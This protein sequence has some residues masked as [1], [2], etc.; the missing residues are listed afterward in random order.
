MG[1]GP[2]ET[3]MPRMAV[4]GPVLAG[5][6]ILGIGMGGMAAW[7]TLAP[8]HSA[9]VA[10]GVLV[11]ETGR[12]TVKHSEGGSIAEVLVREGDV[13]RAGQ[14]LLRL[15]RTEAAARF[16]M[17]TG[18]YRQAR[19]LEARLDAELYERPAIEWPDEL[20][21]LADMPEVAKLIRNQETLFSVRR[22]Q[23]A[24]EI[25]A[26]RERVVSLRDEAESLKEQ[27]VF[28]GQER[29]IV[30]GELETVRSLYD[31]GNATKPRVLEF[32]KE[33]VRL[34]ARD[35]ELGARIAEALQEAVETEAQ[36]A[37]R[38]DERREKILV[39]LQANRAEA[40]RLAE[41]IRDA[42][43]RL[44]T[45]D[46]IAPDAG[47]VVGL[48]HLAPGSVIGAGERL[49]DIVPGEQRLVIEARVAPQD[50]E[51]V[52]VG[53]SSRITLTAYDTRTIGTLIGHVEQVSADR[54]T[55]EAT[56][57]HYFLARIGLDGSSPHEVSRL[58]I[59]PGMPV[60]AHILIAERT[61]LSYLIDPLLR[62][63]HKSFIQQ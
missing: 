60:E 28:M 24:T 56:Q 11:P 33:V 31:K 35:R 2:S 23:L 54:L 47:I 13:V 8:L 63:Y 20:L 5:L 7:A 18:E 26:L 21:S 42:R 19:A 46:V 14:P 12:K 4:A 57:Q 50:I 16:D 32:E 1:E 61:A 48:G 37:Q 27:R 34:E 45:R 36:I 52:A 15:D 59:V 41:Q 53:M 40:L 30:K 58:R 22:T 62:S 44:K 43:N 25:K 3:V 29:A 51:A 10:P 9:V 39:D 55:D 17:L 49:L 6:L 38:L